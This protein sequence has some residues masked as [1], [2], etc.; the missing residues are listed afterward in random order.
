MVIKLSLLLGNARSVTSDQSKSETS[1]ILLPPSLDALPEATFSAT[2][3]VSGSALPGQTVVVYKNDSEVGQTTVDNDSHFVINSV[4]LSKG[5]NAITAKTKDNDKESKVSDEH[6]VIFDNEPP[7]FTL[8]SPSDGLVSHDSF[9]K[10]S[11]KTEQGASVSINSF[12][13]I[14]DSNG[15]FTYNFPL[16]EGDNVLKI[17]ATDTAGNT[18][19]QE[20][21][22]RYEK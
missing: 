14:V 18:T 5:K 11:G 2:I 19:S 8:D 9:V 17:T 15:N 1:D 12:V 10:V 21:K 7:K 20:L 6:D 22:V 4:S 3:A 16:N 13:A